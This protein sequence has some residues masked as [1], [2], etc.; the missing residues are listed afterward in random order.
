MLMAIKWGGAFTTRDPVAQLPVRGRMFGTVDEVDDA[1]GAM[2]GAMVVRA[3]NVAAAQVSRSLDDPAVKTEL[4]AATAEE[5]AR[6]GVS[7][8]VNVLG[9][10]LDPD[11]AEAIRQAR[12]SENAA[13]YAVGSE[14]LVTWSDGNRYPGTVL[15]AQGEQYRV[16][17]PDGQAHWIGA[18]YLSAK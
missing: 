14:V 8:R 5:L 18:G 11:S 10:A 1:Y 3:F 9:I 17:F 4:A 16:G 7:C 12:S 15:E 2:I 13:G 6:E